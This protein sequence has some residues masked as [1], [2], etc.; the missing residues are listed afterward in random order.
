MVQPLYTHERNFGCRI[1]ETIYRGLRTLTLENE[2]VRV[3]FLADKGADIFEFLHKPTD[4]DFLWRSPLGVRNPATFVPTVPRA[5]G[6][7]LDYYE[8]GWQECMPTGGDEAVYAGTQFGPH[9]E[10]CLIPWHYAILEDDPERVQVRFAVRTYRTPFRLEKTVTLERHSGV[11]AF[12]ERLVNE[13]AEPVDFVWGHHPA[14][15]P[16]F[17]DE[18]CVIDLPGARVRTVDL[19][20]TSRCRVGSDYTWPHVAGRDGTTIDLTRIP[21]DQARSHDLAF[22]TDMPEGWYAITNTRRRVGFGMVWPLDVFPVAWFWQVYCGALQQPWYGRTYNVALEPWSTPYK[23][24][25]ESIEH[26]ANCTFGP[27]ETL[28]VEFKAVAYAGLSRVDRI[29][30]DGRVQGRT[31]G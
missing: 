29:H 21:S 8:G 9:G 30:P 1:T 31:E 15:G 27:G 17:L 12:S 28:A 11:L 22:L 10:V 19:G 16:P 23:T 24:I 4:T 20:A 2:I 3:S 26:G 5:E 14:F 7:F 25:G 6:A 13:G 18:S